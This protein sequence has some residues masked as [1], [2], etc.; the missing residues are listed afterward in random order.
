MTA[1]E[2]PR[3][4]AQ[5]VHD[6]DAEADGPLP[7][8]LVAVRPQRLGAARAAEEEWVAEEVPIALEYN[9]LSHAVMLATPLDLEDFALGFSLTEG[10]LAS[11]EDLLDVEVRARPNG[12]ALQLRVTARCEALLKERRRSMAGRTGCGLCGTDNLDQVFRPPSRPVPPLPAALSAPQALVPALS[13]AMRELAAAQP[14]QQRTG[15]I[16]AAAWCRPDG[17]VIMVREDVGRHNALDKL[18]GALAK[19]GIDTSQGFAAV[20]SRASFEMVQKAA[21]AGMPLLAAVS[22]PTH[23]AIRTATACGLALAGFVREGRATRYA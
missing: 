8:A 1:C 22:A 10:L 21:L 23:L 4:G 18:I 6:A 5:G 12:V 2:L 7:A 19:A 14:L 3:S 20:T 11:A 15:G 17:E 13:R 16:H 9:G